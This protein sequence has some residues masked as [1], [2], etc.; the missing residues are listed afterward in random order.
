[1]SSAVEEQ[2]D[3]PLSLFFFFLPLTFWNSVTRL[4]RFRLKTRR[5]NS[6]N[7]LKFLP[8]SAREVLQ[9]FGLLIFRSLVP[10]KRVSDHWKKKRKPS[11]LVQDGNFG[12]VMS[13]NRFDVSSF[14]SQTT[15]TNGEKEVEPGRFGQFWI[16]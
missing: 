16:Q 9:W 15:R 1:M 13:R 7:K 8:V 6:N 10:F 4:N 5:P 2:A 14:I 3:T 12:E 11:S